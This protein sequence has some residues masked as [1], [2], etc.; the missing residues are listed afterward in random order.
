MFYYPGV[1]AQSG[2]IIKNK[3]EEA[4]SGEGLR[5]GGPGGNAIYVDV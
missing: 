2:E 5:A 1:L 4:Q 3:K